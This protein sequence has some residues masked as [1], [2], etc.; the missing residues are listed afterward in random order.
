[1][2]LAD[3]AQEKNELVQER[4]KLFQKCCVLTNELSKMKLLLR[5]SPAEKSEGK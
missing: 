1:M 2:S 4:D 5:K 3:L